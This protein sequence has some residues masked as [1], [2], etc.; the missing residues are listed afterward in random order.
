MLKNRRSAFIA[1]ASAL[2][3]AGCESDHA[4]PANVDEI[5]NS[6][7]NVAQG[8]AFA[9]DESYTKFVEAEAAGRLSMDECKAPVLTAPAPGAMLDRNAPPTISFMPTQPACGQASPAGAARTGRAPALCRTPPRGRWA[10]LWR[11]ISPI[12][13]AEAHCPAVDGLNYLL[14]ISDA[15]DKNVYSALLS[16]TSFSPKEDLWRKAMAGRGGQTLRVTIQRALFVR[17]GIMD[18]P[19]IN[20]QPFSLTV[21]P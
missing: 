18:G 11:M 5:V 10:R 15:G 20:K 21:A 17:G 9:S 6:C 8:E 13:V 19:F 1:M 2:S 4:G 3:L 16:V 12:G 7:E 14:K